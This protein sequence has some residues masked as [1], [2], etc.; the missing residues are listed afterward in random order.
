MDKIVYVW[1]SIGGLLLLAEMLIPGASLLWL[2]LSA[3][4]MGGLMIL[5]PD[6]SALPQALIFGVFAAVGVGVYLRFF[7]S[8]EPI[9]DRPL[10]NKRA[11]QLVGREF[12]LTEAIRM[13][14]GKVKL[15]DAL[16]TVE[17]PDMAAGSRVTVISTDGIVLKVL[18]A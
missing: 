4:A 12:E 17:G 16:W 5:F 13:G 3:L 2:G 18:S 9:T 8:R 1:W 11:A 7:R 10:L 6:L 15:G 14:R